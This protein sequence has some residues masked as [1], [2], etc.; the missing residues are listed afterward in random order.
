MNY[1]IWHT[2]KTFLRNYCDI[3]FLYVVIDKR[4]D[5]ELFETFDKNNAEK[6]CKALNEA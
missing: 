1:Y 5:M 3:R 4:I 2:A 6:V